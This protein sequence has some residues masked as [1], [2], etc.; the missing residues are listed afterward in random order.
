[1]NPAIELKITKDL[2]IPS[3]TPA[4]QEKTWYGRVWKV[5]S[6]PFVWLIEK[7]V[8]FVND[9]FSKPKEDTN[10]SPIKK[11]DASSLAP[12]NDTGPI[13][14]TVIENIT[15]DLEGSV[16]FLK[17]SIIPSDFESMN[18]LSADQTPLKDQLEPLKKLSFLSSAIQNNIHLAIDLWAE[19]NEDVQKTLDSVINAL[20]D[21]IRTKFHE[22]LEKNAASLIALFRSVEKKIASETNLSQEFLKEWADILYFIK[23]QIEDVNPALLPLKQVEAE[24]STS[25]K[26]VVAHFNK[27]ATAQSIQNIEE[28]KATN[29]IRGI[30]NIWNSCYMNS[31]LQAMFASTRIS[32]LIDQSI[33][34]TENPDL[35]C[36]TRPNIEVR[37]SLKNFRNLYCNV[38][39]KSDAVAN[40]LLTKGAQDL[41][42]TI[43]STRISPVLSGLTS[44]QDA[45]E[46][47]RPLLETIGV[48]FN[49]KIETWTKENSAEKPHIQVAPHERL[50]LLELPQQKDPLPFEKLLESY[51][52]IESTKDPVNKWRNKY[53][54]TEKKWS[55]SEEIPNIL[56]VQLK[57]MHWSRIGSKIET[58]VT[59][60]DMVDF[61]PI[62]D[63]ELKQSGESTHFK[64]CSYVNHYGTIGGGHY[65]ANRKDTGWKKCNDSIVSDLSAANEADD[66]K[67]AYLLVFERVV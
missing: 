54:T 42:Q 11:P 55:I 47:M 4:E 44:Q 10:S 12:R 20:K 51:A 38:E 39:K 37:Q 50:L 41:R 16:S 58:P 33:P 19:S 3:S 52:Q 61:A 40:E 13:N 6:S 53:V 25:L 5:I 30:D 67:D 29:V 62:I 15:K 28:T 65:T 32:A 1:M 64:L 18:S 49:S 34:L 17:D 35:S 8:A 59:V 43:F 27:T 66:R 63:S 9:L 22:E 7:I 26:Y 57:R 56:V 24:V 45:P 60:G 21:E 14:T 36:S 46:L 31:V 23:N 2:P 48:C